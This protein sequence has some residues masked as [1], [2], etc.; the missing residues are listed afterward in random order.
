MRGG[1]EAVEKMETT[2]R[3]G[4]MMV[5]GNICTSIGRTPG[6]VIYVV[7]C[8]VVSASRTNDDHSIT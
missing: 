7:G 1:G 5:A 8:G 2:W 3:G 4:G 6:C